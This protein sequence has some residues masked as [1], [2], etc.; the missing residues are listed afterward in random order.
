MVGVLV[1]LNFTNVL[2]AIRLFCAQPNVMLILVYYN[3]LALNHTHIG[4]PLIHTKYFSANTRSGELY[5]R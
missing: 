5:V 2:I 3:L 4:A 1:F